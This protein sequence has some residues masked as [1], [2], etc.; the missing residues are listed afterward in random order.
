MEITDGHV[1]EGIFTGISIAGIGRND[2]GF[3]AG[4]SGHEFKDAAEGVLALN[5]AIEEQAAGVVEHN[6]KLVGGNGTDKEVGIIGGGRDHGEDF[7]VTGVDS[8]GGADT[9]TQGLFQCSLEGKVDRK[10]NVVA[11]NGRLA[12]KDFNEE[13]FPIDLDNFLTILTMEDIFIFTFNAVFTDEV[14]H[15]VF[16][17]EEARVIARNFSDIADDMAGK[18]TGGIEAEG[19]DGNIDCGEFMQTLGNPGSR[20]NRDIGS[21]FSRFE[22]K[23]FT[24]I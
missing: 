16:T 19:I 24:G 11:G 4:D 10:D 2:T 6:R 7:T 3:E 21:N 12:V 9:V 14:M 23:A 13:R 18:V 5:S 20:I 15:R 22:G 1:A 8:D 17:A